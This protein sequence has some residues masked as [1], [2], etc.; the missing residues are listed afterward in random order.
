MISALLIKLIDKCI[1]KK[2]IKKRRGRCGVACNKTKSYGFV[3][4]TTQHLE[5]Y[6]VSG[7]QSIITVGYIGCCMQD[8][9]ILI[10]EPA[11]IDVLQKERKYKITSDLC[12]AHV[13][14]SRSTYT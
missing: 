3:S 10:N 13:S 11:T 8:T 7:E 5:Y 1:I 14:M 12:R 2:S 6:R 9:Y 4:R